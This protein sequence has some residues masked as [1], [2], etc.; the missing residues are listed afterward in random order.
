M[1]SLVAVTAAAAKPE[2]PLVL[3]PDWPLLA[4]AVALDALVAAAAVAAATRLR[5]R[6]PERTAEAAAA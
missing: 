1:L 3:T 6:A 4:A 2:P 5:G